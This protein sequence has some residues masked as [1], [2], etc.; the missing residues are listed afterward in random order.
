MQYSEFFCNWIFWYR[1][2]ENF[3]HISNFQN[4]P[5][6]LNVCRILPQSESDLQNILAGLW[7]RKKL[8]DFT[9]SEVV[10]YSENLESRGFSFFKSFSFWRFYTDSDYYMS[11]I[12]L[13]ANILIIRSFLHPVYYFQI[14]QIFKGTDGFF[15]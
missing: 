1:N 3:K 10:E 12:F 14:L 8:S 4:F 11:R 7:I 6:I 9:I 15:F 5:S 13:V 2:E